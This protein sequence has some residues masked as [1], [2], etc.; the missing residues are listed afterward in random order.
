[1]RKCFARRDFLWEPVVPICHTATMAMCR[2]CALGCKSCSF[3]GSQLELARS[4]IFEA[5][6][7]DMLVISSES[8]TRTLRQLSDQYVDSPSGDAAR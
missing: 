2:G 7:L 5:A 8:I 6:L 4:F 3:C 1:M